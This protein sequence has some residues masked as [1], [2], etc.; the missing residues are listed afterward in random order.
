MSMSK[1]SRSLRAAETITSEVFDAVDPTKPREMGLGEIML[2]GSTCTAIAIL[3]Y[4][5][6]TGSVPRASRWDGD[7]LSTPRTPYEDEVRFRLLDIL[8]YVFGGFVITGMSAW[9]VFH[10]VPGI[11]QHLLWE[12]EGTGVSG[13]VVAVAGALS[14]FGVTW[15][16]P[17]EPTPTQRRKK[18]HEDMNKQSQQPHRRHE[19]RLGA[20]GYLRGAAAASPWALADDD[21][22]VA[23]VIARRRAL[24]WKQLAWASACGLLGVGLAPFCRVSFADFFRASGCTAGVVGS[25]S[26]AAMD[27]LTYVISPPFLSVCGFL[28]MG[29][30]VGMMALPTTEN[31]LDAMVH[32]GCE[33]A[34]AVFLCSSF[35]HNLQTLNMEAS[36]SDKFDPING[37]MVTQYVCFNK[38]DTR[39]RISLLPSALKRTQADI[40]GKSSWRFG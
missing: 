21:A 17:Y 5:R 23:N 4:R 8:N 40:G 38:V 30:S 31:T 15:S 32:K 6:S 16:M 29:A 35:L 19:H 39:K 1:I 14:M 9:T 7:T 27:S 20:V 26:L 11:K 22:T 28:V 13:L 18:R 37:N 34:A 24:R 25:L 33:F 2:T 36:F 3:W 12:P 10:L